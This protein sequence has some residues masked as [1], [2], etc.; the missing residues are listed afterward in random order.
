MDFPGRNLLRAECL[1]TKPGIAGHGMN[2]QHCSRMAWCGMGY[3]YER[4]Y[5]AVRRC[6]RHG[7]QREVVVHVIG[8]RT[9]EHAWRVVQSEGA[10]S[11]ADL[12]LGGSNWPRC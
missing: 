11:D 12:R 10:G 6:W 4:V 7:Q 1:I 3:S 8:D 9:A 2:W 5:Q